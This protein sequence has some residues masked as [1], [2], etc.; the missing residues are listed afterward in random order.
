M[1][2][3]LYILD[4]RD[5]YLPVYK[6]HF[7]V[8]KLQNV[9]DSTRTTE[10]HILLHMQ[11]YKLYILCFRMCCASRLTVSLYWIKMLQCHQDKKGFLPWNKNQQNYNMCFSASELEILLHGQETVLLFHRIKNVAMPAGL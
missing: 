6:L 5:V 10:L 3:I 1:I 7:S 11:D 8:S 4:F 2:A 9:A